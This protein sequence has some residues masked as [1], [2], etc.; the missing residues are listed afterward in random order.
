M[1]LSLLNLDPRVI[2]A[3]IVWYIVVGL[4]CLITGF[5]GGC[6]FKQNQWDAEKFKQLE[7][8]QK[9][10][11][12]DKVDETKSATEFTKAKEQQGTGKAF[13]EQALS[14]KPK[15]TRTVEPRIIGND[16]SCASGNG[17]GEG[18]INVVVKEGTTQNEKTGTY[19]TADFMRLYD[20]SIQPGD[21][22]LQSRT[23]DEASGTSVDEGFEKVIKVNNLNYAACR[24][25][26]STL[27]DRIIQKQKTFQQGVN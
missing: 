16:G 17:T 24:L 10:E 4:L 3:K 18:K 21:I 2:L 14:K 27:I 23:Y 20:V 8:T 5:Y 11:K 22:E 15:L 7:K 13:V 12:Q 26:L 9:L 1:D 19:F 25:Q 6:Q